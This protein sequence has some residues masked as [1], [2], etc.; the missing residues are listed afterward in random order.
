MTTTVVTDPEVFRARI[1]P[2]L[3]PIDDLKF[4]DI[5]VDQML[6]PCEVTLRYIGTATMLTT[7]KPY[8]QTYISQLRVESGRVVRFREYFD[9]RA[10]V[11]ALTPG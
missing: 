9:R 2:V 11:A 1:G 6:D 5:V 7:G 8:R 3:A 4:S 10:L